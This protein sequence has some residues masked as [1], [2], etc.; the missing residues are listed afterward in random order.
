ME[1]RV[2]PP[3][4]IQSQDLHQ[5]VEREDF[6]ILRHDTATVQKL[7]QIHVNFKMLKRYKARHFG[8]SEQKHA[9]KQNISELQDTKHN[10]Q[11][12]FRTSRH[13][14]F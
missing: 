3:P 12:I 1:G 11:G 13:A 5:R 2:H 4:A 7:R 10:K 6:C 9:I 14:S 8:T